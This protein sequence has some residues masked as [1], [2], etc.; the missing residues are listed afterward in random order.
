[1]F[2]SIYLARRHPEF[3]RDQF[4]KRWRQH[5]AL[6]M[7]KGFFNHIVGYVQ[8]EPIAFPGTSKEF[9]AVARITGRQYEMGQTD[10]DELQA[11]VADEYETFSGPILP[12]LLRV[13]ETV[14]KAAEPGGVTAFLFFVDADRASTVA[15]V[16]AQRDV[17]RLVLNVRCEELT[18]GEMSSEIPYRAVIEI[19]APTVDRLAEVLVQESTAPWRSADL[20]VVTRECVMWHRIDA[21]TDQ[22]ARA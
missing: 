10:F 13:R 2:K 19:S 8:A 21:G 1:M 18:I 12:V 15:T 20:A 6:A 11:M 16:Y 7:S 22:G 4:V 5:G 3:S 14:L 9:D 17:D